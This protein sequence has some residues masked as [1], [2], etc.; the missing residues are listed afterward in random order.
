MR[1][2]GRWT[3]NAL[4]V[5]SLLLWVVI[6]VLW[7]RS[8][9]VRD[10]FDKLYTDGPRRYAGEAHATL[11]SGVLIFGDFKLPTSVW[12]SE[13]V[14]PSI[15]H[16]QTAP[17]D[18]WDGPAFDMAG[19]SPVRSFDFPGIT[20]S[21]LRVTIHVDLGGWFDAR[22]R[23]IHS[24]S[25]QLATGEAR[26]LEIRLNKVVPALAVLPL[27]S[28]ARPLLRSRRRRSGCP[29]CAY[30]LTGNVSGVCPE[31]GTAVAVTT[32]EVRCAAPNRGGR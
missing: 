28:V 24:T 7:V 8:Y 1:R 31:C 2:L 22:K 4:T 17:D 32:P 10:S 30:D 27:L 23:P 18:P 11:N 14:S 26:S 6:A 21:T 12:A 3:L 15:Q 13:P 16:K 9:W 19:Y 20:S 25:G 29:S 5:L